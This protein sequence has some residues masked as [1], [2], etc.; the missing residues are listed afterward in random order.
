MNAKS[1]NPC[2]G[3]FVAAPGFEVSI[4]VVRQRIIE[5]NPRPTFLLGT[6]E[7]AKR[8]GVTVNR[9]LEIDMI[10]LVR[11]EFLACVVPG[12]DDLCIDL[13]HSRWTSCVV[14]SLCLL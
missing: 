4:E 1:G 7:S 5:F 6:V 8:E 12:L 13:L 11:I 9:Q 14:A 3:L 10:E 2:D